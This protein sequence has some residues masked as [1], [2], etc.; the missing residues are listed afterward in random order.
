MFYFKTI[1]IDNASPELVEK[2]IRRYTKFRS[3][4]L[5]FLITSGEFHGD[6]IFSGL[7]KKDSLLITRIT[8]KPL[9]A[10]FEDHKPIREQ[11]RTKTFVR[12][13]KKKGFS[14]YQ[15]RYGSLHIIISCLMFCW[16]IF[17]V[18]QLFHHRFEFS[19]LLTLVYFCG[20]LINAN[21]EIDKA[22]E[23][24]DKAIQITRTDINTCSGTAP[25]QVLL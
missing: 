13:N 3:S 19:I 11:N 24:I 17:G 25:E 21:R 2:A 20:L 23:L 4:Y 22:R 18:W 10:N 9:P 8:H 15:I 14:S 12:F 6:K 5:D 16:F 7:E 1:T